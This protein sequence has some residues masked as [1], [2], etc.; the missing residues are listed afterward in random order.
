MTTARL[1]MLYPGGNTSSGFHSFYDYIIPVDARRIYIIKGG[2]GVGKSTFMESIGKHLLQKGYD[3]EFHR[4]SS[5]NDSLDGVV[6]PALEVALIDGTA[7]H[8]VDPKNP[9]AVDEIIHLGDHWNEEGIAAHK[10]EILRVN[11]E[12]GH[13]FR[14]AYGHLAQ[15]KILNNEV[16]SFYTDSGALDFYGLQKKADALVDKIFEEQ[17]RER[18]G[19]DRHLFASAITPNG[20]ENHFQTL[21]DHL[22]T[23]IIVT[24]PAGTGKSTMVRSVYE[25]A[26]RRGF[27]VEAF[28]CALIPTQIEHL[29]IPELDIGVITSTKYHRYNAQSGDMV[30]DTGAFINETRLEPYTSDLYSSHTLFEEALQRAISFIY[31]AKATHDEL[32]KYYSP[33][34]DFTEIDARRDR[35]LEKILSFA[36]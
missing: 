27:D 11:R 8:V 10:Q 6:I 16:E 19:R 12:V 24:G 32:E 35:V 3:V 14:K 30:V 4:C 5:D 34:M 9:G 20:L 21:F 29:I 23:R 17:S 33:Y 15:A 25:T 1:R 2:P 18:L 26:I 22:N 36:K 28:H 13:L 31:R 7:P